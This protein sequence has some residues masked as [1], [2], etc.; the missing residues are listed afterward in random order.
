MKA[1]I[2]EI[3]DSVAAVLSE[4]GIV[5]KIRNRIGKTIK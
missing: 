5:S 4:D 2:V 1:V 3:K